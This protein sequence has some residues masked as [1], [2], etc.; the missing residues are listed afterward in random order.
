M[1][2]ETAVDLINTLVYRPEWRFE[3]EPATNRFEDGVRV[4]VTYQA[5][6]TNRNQAPE[7]SEWIPNGARA[8]Y[9]LMVRPCSTPDDIC[10]K[11][12]EEVIMPIEEHE[13]REFLRYPDTLI[14]PFHPHNHDTMTAWGHPETDLTFGLA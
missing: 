10:R 3:A 1:N 12:I 8:S 14:A 13:A 9:V 2:T 7:Y 11:L 6:N 5:R 4:K